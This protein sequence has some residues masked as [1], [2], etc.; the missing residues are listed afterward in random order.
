[1]GEVGR[2]LWRPPSPASLPKQSRLQ[3]VAHPHKQ[4]NIEIFVEQPQYPV[5]MNNSM[6]SLQ[7]LSGVRTGHGPLGYEI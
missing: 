5:R 1:M 3:Q 6:K 2:D 4:R 7:K